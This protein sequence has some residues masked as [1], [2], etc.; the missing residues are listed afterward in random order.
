MLVKLTQHI[1]EGGGV[2]C[3]VRRGKVTPFVEGAIIEASDATAA[4]WIGKGW[5]EAAAEPEQAESEGES[6]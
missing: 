3:A 5:A 1:M 4:K 6:E 2:K